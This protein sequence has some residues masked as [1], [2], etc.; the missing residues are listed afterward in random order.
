[1]PKP[2]DFFVCVI[3]EGRAFVA[4]KDVQDSRKLPEAENNLKSLLKSRSKD[5]YFL[6]YINY[7]QGVRY[8]VSYKPDNNFQYRLY[9]VIVNELPKVPG[10]RWMDYIDFLKKSQSEIAKNI[11]SAGNMM[12]LY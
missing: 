2:T 3:P 8:S 7:D 6:L 12:E 11:I 1:M 10:V 9:A 4:V 5:D